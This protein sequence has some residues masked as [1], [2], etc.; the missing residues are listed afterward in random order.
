MVEN[1][2]KVINKMLEKC[3]E[4]EKVIQRLNDL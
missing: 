4:H 3:I 2:V 1:D